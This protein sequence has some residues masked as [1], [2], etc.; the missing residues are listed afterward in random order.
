LRPRPTPLNLRNARGGRGQAHGR[1]LDAPAATAARDRRLPSPRCV[2][3]WS[4]LRAFPDRY[5]PR[6][7]DPARLLL[8]S[9]GSFLTAEGAERKEPGR[10]LDLPTRYESGSARASRQRA[11][12]TTYPGTHGHGP[13]QQRNDDDDDEPKLLVVSDWQLA[14][15]DWSDGDDDGEWVTSIERPARDTAQKAPTADVA[16]GSKA[17]C[18][19]YVGVSFVVDKYAA[20]KFQARIRFKSK[21]HYICCCPTAE[22]A[23]RAYDAV[24]WIIP[25][26]KLNFL[27]TIPAAASS[28]W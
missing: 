15:S 11:T 16:L 7:Q 13:P 27:T 24:A 23:A 6:R 21:Q 14:D 18:A 19:Q 9:L 5:F 17:D 10:A 8:P 20:N 1:R 4:Q 22:A 26:R 3:E 12:L 28:S 2:H 25:E